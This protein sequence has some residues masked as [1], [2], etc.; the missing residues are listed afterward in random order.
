L[1]H[2]AAFFIYISHSDLPSALATLSGAL[3]VS[4]LVF[5]FVGCS[6]S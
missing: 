4:G 2:Q 3:N 5:M 1:V 6:I